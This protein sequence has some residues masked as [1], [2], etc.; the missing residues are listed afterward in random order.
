MEDHHLMDNNTKMFENDE[1]KIREILDDLLHNYQKNKLVGV[2]HKEM[3][4]NIGI[5]LKKLY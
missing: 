4:L 3:E 1:L 5:S 2:Q